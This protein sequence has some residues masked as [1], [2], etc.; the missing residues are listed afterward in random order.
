VARPARLALAPSTSPDRSHEL[1]GC[2]GTQGIVSVDADTA[3]RARVWRRTAGRVEFSEQ[4]FPN[5]F[6]TTSLDLLAHLP[7]RRLSADWLRTRHGQVATHEPLAVVELESPGTGVDDAYRYLVLTMHL[8]EVQTALVEMSNKRDGGEARTLADL[9]GLV[10]IWHPVEQ[11]LTLTGQTYFKGMRFD[12]LHRLQFDLETTGLNEDRD[13]IFMISLR[14]SRGWQDCL[15]TRELSEAEV[16]QRFGEAIR[17][18]DPDVLENHNIFAFDLSFLV[19]R[20]ARL[21]V[22]LGI[23]RDGSE[24]WLETDVFD[25]GERPEPFLRWRVAGREVIDTQHAVRRFGVAA[26][27]LRRHGL[28][29][30]ARYFGFARTDREYVPGAEVWPTYRSD[31]E[32]IKRYAAA[33]VEEVDGLSRRLLPTAFGL[34]SMLP[35]AY[36]RIAA[37]CGPASLWE[38]MLVRAYLHQGHAI[39]A[40]VPRLQHPASRPRAELFLTGVVG[41]SARAVLRPLLPCVLSSNA[42]AAA[43]DNLR[44]LPRLVKRLVHDQGSESAQ[45]LA[46]AAYAYLA[47][48]SLFSDP[49]AANEVSRIARGYLDRLLDDLRARGCTVLA[50]DGEEVTLGLPDAWGEAAERDLSERAVAYLPDGVHVVFDSHYQAT[51]VRGARTAITLG[52]DGRVTLIGSAFRAGRLQ[53]FGETFMYRA[54]PCALAGEATGLRRVFLETVHQLRTGQVPLED[55]CVQVTLHKSV[56]QYRRGGTH[57]EPYEVLLAAGIRSWRVGQRIRYFRARGG[58][59]RLLQEGDAVDA[60]EADT[61][62]YVQRLCGLYCQQFAQAF[63]RE[64]FARIFRL[65]SGPGPFDEPEA[66]LADIRPITTPVR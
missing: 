48:Q 40:P 43:N 51:Y 39:A 45:F 49:E 13:R 54:A 47:G 58:E 10:L 44:V 27:D 6:L 1:F 29:D 9:R 30:A 16:I 5:W 38:L 46:G 12:D 59:P 53:R 3:G 50:L 24:P 21:G 62:Y 31:P 11:Y 61:E 52:W 42:I 23:G 57:E 32:R 34:A 2:A 22:R 4:R 65:P 36:E 18:R 8:H 37:D 63:R 41:P 25:A 15:E 60:S 35:R 56:P 33:D 7:A 26:P 28:K 19:K 17:A 14:D 55:L 64:D 66:D 20:A